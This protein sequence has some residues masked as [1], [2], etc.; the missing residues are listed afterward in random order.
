M[1]PPY[2]LTAKRTY[3]LL[4]KDSKQ[5]GHIVIDYHYHLHITIFLVL[6]NILTKY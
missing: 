2:I 3:L 1:L 6:V 4:R 5:Y